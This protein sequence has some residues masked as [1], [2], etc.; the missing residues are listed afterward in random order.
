M[1][2]FRTLKSSPFVVFAALLCAATSASAQAPIDLGTASNFA[3]L[4]GSGITVAGAVLTSPITG[5]IGTSPTAT[6]TGFG[7]VI[8]TGTNH[9]GDAT[10]LAA[11]TALAT[12]YTNAAGRTPTTTYGAAF[13]LGGLAAIGGIEQVVRSGHDS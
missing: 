3:I 6:I 7:N 10:T 8:L 1:E 9:A 2:K 5:D 4:G 11:K 12:A 13:E